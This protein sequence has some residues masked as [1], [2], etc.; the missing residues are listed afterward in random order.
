MF[1]GVFYLIEMGILVKRFFY[2]FYGWVLLF[3]WYG[4]KVVSGVIVV[5]FVWLVYGVWG[6]RDVRNV[7]LVYWFSCF[8]FVIFWRILRI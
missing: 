2:V 8:Y 5:S 7:L 1:N 6:I 4:F 3:Y